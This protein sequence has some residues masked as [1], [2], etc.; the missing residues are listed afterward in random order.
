MSKFFAGLIMNLWTAQ[1]DP[2]NSSELFLNESDETYE[3]KK[4]LEVSIHANILHVDLSCLY[5]LLHF[6]FLT[7]SYSMR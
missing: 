4:N 1:S 5:Q 7:A 3:E 6:V 2:N